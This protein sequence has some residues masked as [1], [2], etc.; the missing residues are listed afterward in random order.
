MPYL[1]K[2]F[3]NKKLGTQR[4]NLFQKQGQ[5]IYNLLNNFGVFCL[6]LH[7]DFHS[8]KSWRSLTNSVKNWAIRNGGNSG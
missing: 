2:N 3:L 1:S 8:A 5:T 6:L 7:T 4:L